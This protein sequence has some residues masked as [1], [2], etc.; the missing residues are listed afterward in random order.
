MVTAALSLVVSL[1]ALAVL[2][3][4]RY[5]DPL[6]GVS[7]RVTRKVWCPMEDRTFF[8][9]LEEDVWDGRRRDIVCCSAFSPP[10]AITCGK[11]CLRVT[12]RPRPVTISRL[13]VVF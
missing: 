1:L 12:E 9:R 13:P 5:R 7:R 2:L 11:G 6:R 3:V 4:L 10:T 8:A